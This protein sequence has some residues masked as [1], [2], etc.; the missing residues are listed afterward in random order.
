MDVVRKPLT[1]FK[2]PPQIRQDLGSEAELRNLGESLRE[3]QLSSLGALANGDLIF[4]FRRLAGAKLVGLAELEVRI[5]SEPLSEAEIKLIQLTENIHRLDMSPPEKWAA[6]EQ[7]RALHPHWSAKELAAHLK[8]DP[9][10]ITKWLSPSKCIKPWQE[11]FKEGRVLISDC[12]VASQASGDQQL[13]LLSLKLSGASRDVLKRSLAKIKAAP[14]VPG[15]RSSRISVGLSEGTK[16]VIAG[17]NL[18]LSDVIDRL[19]E[20]LDAAKKGLKEHLDART[21]Q[22][23]MRDKANAAEGE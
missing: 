7:I 18:S 6:Y 16:I 1:W 17:P 3:R 14:E 10:A 2:V 4:G 21:W 22:S 9:P 8:L 5:Y 11:A 13:E 23:V 12:Y 15:A 20:C 19:A